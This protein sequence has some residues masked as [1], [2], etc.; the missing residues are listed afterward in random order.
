VFELPTLT[1]AAAKAVQPELRTA[2]TSL[3]M[4][5]NDLLALP[6]QE[7]RWYAP[8]Y[9]RSGLGILA[10]LPQVGKTPLAVQLA[11]AIASGGMWMDHV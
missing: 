8:G 7:V 4:D 2:P 1:V 11:I 10:G 6:H 9:V 3:P 5:I